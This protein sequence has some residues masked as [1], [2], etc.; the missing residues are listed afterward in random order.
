M[1]KNEG[2]GSG[3]RNATVDK[4]S[5]QSASTNPGVTRQKSVGKGKVREFVQIFNQETDSTPAAD[6]EKRSQSY[7]RKNGGADQ[8]E[9]EASSGAAKAKQKDVPLKVLA[10]VDEVERTEWWLWMH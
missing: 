3:S 6:V 5:L 1:K 9:S 10:S 2:T 8:K 7:R 4:P